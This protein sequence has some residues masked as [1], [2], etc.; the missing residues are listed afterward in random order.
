[1]PRPLITAAIL[2]VTLSI[3]SSTSVTHADPTSSLDRSADPVVLTG[4]QVP[5]LQGLAPGDIVGFANVSG[6]WQQIPVQV[7]ERAVKNIGDI[8]DG[9]MSGTN[10][11][12]YTDPFTYTGADP[13]PTFDQDDEIVFMAADAGGTPATFSEPPGVV[14][15]TGVR[16][17]ISDPLAPAQSGAVFLFQQDGTLDPAAGEQYVDYDF[18]L[19]PGC[20]SYIPN[21]DVVGGVATGPGANPEDSEVVTPNYTH[22]FSDRWISD[23]LTITLGGASGVD[24]LDRH[25][26]LFA[27][28]QCG[29]S[30]NTFSA[31]HGA[32]I[33]NKSG[34]V[35]ALRSYIGA[36][37]GPQTQRDHV[38][39]AQ[40]QDII[41]N[42]RV[43]TIPSIMDFFDY[44]AAASG[45]TYRNNLNTAGVTIDGVPDAVLPGPIT[46]EQV[47]GPQGTLTHVAQ[48][49]TNIGGFTYTS[50][51]VDDVAP[52]VT[53]CTGDTSAFG[54]SGVWVN[55]S[56]PCTDPH[57]TCTGLLST[58]RTIYYDAP[59]GDA[60]S[61]A[62]RAAEANAPLTVAVAPWL[63]PA[64]DTDGDGIL[65]GVDN[66]P[67]VPNNAQ[68]NND[69][70]LIDMPSKPYDD[71][72]LAASD[73][74][75]DACDADDDNDGIPD[76]LEGTLGPHCP[77]ASAPTNPLLQ[78][79]D[80]DRVI[81]GVEC[82]LG[83]DPASA[84]STPAAVVAPDA[85][86][87]GVPDWAD[88]VASSNDSDGDGVLD[89][90]EFRNYGTLV[91]SPN[92]D[93]DNCGDAREVASINADLT[94]NV[95]DLSQLAQ[96]F[97]LS[98]APQYIANF[99]VT[100]DGSINVID[101]Q[102]V[103]T[104]I[105]PCP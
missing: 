4:V 97:G 24:I 94:V 60:A 61:A 20:L 45:M 67:A 65:D 89:G 12:A 70:N 40:R 85:D 38:F 43:H 9:T 59:G 52:S 25:K 26:A 84:A 96:S 34:P 56:V 73:E 14:P 18:C 36:N 66:C 19:L 82:L 8:Y 86:G 11:L 46:W 29:R 39:Y 90:R 3:G 74:M 105:G 22:H 102:F 87:D 23:E 37:S 81:D 83:S 50:Y 49:R 41:T 64:A 99:D 13:I 72:T 75:G 44:S 5:T 103:A 100:K 30:E 27:P 53:Q 1:M 17:L 57:P 79:T 31:S 2:A 88:Q 95:L 51:Y 78:D 101:L 77:S 32:F 54:S 104:H 76:A 16:V 7:D 98:T 93:G 33:V 42:L 58:T 69:R 21:Y 28:G 47:T 48:V 91:S 10:V 35:R 63:D 68:A 62:Q 92:S 80:G 55:Q 71:I 6:L 15:A